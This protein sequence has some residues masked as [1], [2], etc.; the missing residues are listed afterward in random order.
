MAIV[1]DVA[2]TT[3]D[4]IEVN[5]N[6]GGFPVIIVDTAGLRDSNDKIEKLGID[7]ALSKIEESN[8]VIEVFTDPEK[9][10]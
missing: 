10:N 8:A 5:L 7:I 4:A 2:G 6:I 3:R 1:S 9:N